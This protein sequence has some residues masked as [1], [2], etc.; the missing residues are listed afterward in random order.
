MLLRDV[1][2]EF[3]GRHSHS[4]LR[5]E[6]WQEGVKWDTPLRGTSSGASPAAGLGTQHHCFPCLR[7]LGIPR[8]PPLHPNCSE[9]CKKAFLSFFYWKALMHFLRKPFLKGSLK[10]KLMEVIIFLSKL[11]TSAGLADCHS[12][13]L[14][15]Y[16]CGLYS[17]GARGHHLSCSIS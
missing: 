4:H 15:P 6:H 9:N 17:A 5:Q 13:G 12:P 14:A 8:A 7:K 1:I 2:V 11:Q 10:G 3:I 16:L